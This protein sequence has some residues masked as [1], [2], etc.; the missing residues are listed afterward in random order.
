MKGS[1]LD[2]AKAAASFVLAERRWRRPRAYVFGEGAAAADFEFRPAIRLQP[3]DATQ[4]A[5]LSYARRGEGAHP[6][7]AS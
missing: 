2:G 7:G 4:T 5:M 6:A 1:K 3:T